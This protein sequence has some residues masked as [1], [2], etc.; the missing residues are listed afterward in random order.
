MSPDPGNHMKSSFK[1]FIYYGQVGLLYSIL[2]LLF[3]SLSISIRNGGHPIIGYLFSILSI[4]I[5]ISILDYYIIA[6]ECLS[7]EMYTYLAFPLH[8]YSINH[9]RKG[10]FTPTIYIPLLSFIFNV[11]YF[12]TSGVELYFS[13]HNMDNLLI[14]MLFVIDFLYH[15]YSIIYIIPCVIT[16]NK[17]VKDILYI[18]DYR[19]PPD[20]ENVN[21]DDN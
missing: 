2:I 1:D 11:V 6:L 17:Y 16:I 12:L 15:L 3:S 5:A 14:V 10:I 9:Y 18:Y 4:G 19:I 21:S 7:N 20:K 8:C 13:N